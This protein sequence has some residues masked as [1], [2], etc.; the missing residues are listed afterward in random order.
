[1]WPLDS[2]CSSHDPC[3]A[4]PGFLQCCR[5]LRP[6][7]AA[8]Q[9][10]VPG[11]GC[12]GS[13]EGRRGLQPLLFRRLRCQRW[14]RRRCRRRRSPPGP[15]D[16]LRGG[17]CASCGQDVLADQS[18]ELGKT[19]VVSFCCDSCCLMRGLPWPTRSSLSA[20]SPSMPW[21]CPRCSSSVRSAPCSSSSAD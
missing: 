8:E 3:P 20:G 2:T 18:C 7:S 9:R 19:G 10:E 21:W 14:L 4:L 15:R 6:P 12:T 1:M 13:G 11:A 5:G 16:T 17:R